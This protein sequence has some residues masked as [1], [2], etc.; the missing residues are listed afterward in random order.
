MSDATIQL[1]HFTQREHNSNNGPLPD[2]GGAREVELVAEGGRQQEV[3]Q[4]SQGEVVGVADHGR[5]GRGAANEVLL[6]V[7]SCNREHPS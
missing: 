3:V 4:V 1:R 6:S 2:P 5:G 7:G